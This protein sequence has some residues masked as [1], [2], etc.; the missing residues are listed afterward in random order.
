MDAAY[1]QMI[2]A[3]RSDLVP[4]LFILEYSSSWEVRNLLLVPSFFFTTSCI[5]A[6]R[7][8]SDRARRKG[9]VLCYIMLNRIPPE[10]KVWIISRG[11]SVKPDIVRRQFEQIRPVSELG[12]NLRGWTLDVLTIVHKIKKREFNLKDVYAFEEELSILHPNNKHVRPKIRQQLQIL[13]DFGLLTFVE[14]GVYRLR[15]IV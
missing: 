2:A 14:R 6:R 1:S 4:N 15:T 10:G 12:T 5:V 13:R 3:I 11:T 8:L 9:H 7:P